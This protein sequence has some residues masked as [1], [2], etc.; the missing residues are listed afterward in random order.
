MRLSTS[1]INRF[2][3]NIKKT[4][5]CWIWL[6]STQKGY[7]AFKA[8]NTSYRC[9]RLMWEIVKS[10]IPKGMYVLHKCDVRNCVNP[11]HL[12]LGTAQDNIND[13]IKKGRFRVASGKNHGTK[14]KPERI[15][16][17]SKHGNSKLNEKIVSDI[18]SLYKKCSETHL[19]LA[20]KYGV[21]EGCIQ[22]IINK[23]VWT[24][25]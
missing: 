14:T 9:H 24:H 10:P 23:N 21:T 6:M 8:N 12:F 1:Q 25:V 11:K 15:A 22:Q 5:T 17:G 20:K 16:R 18:R 19:S 4:N 7:G 2:I 13:C 3:S